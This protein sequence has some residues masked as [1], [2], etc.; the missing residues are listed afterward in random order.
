MTPPK[1]D[2]YGPERTSREREAGEAEVGQLWPTVEAERTLPVAA[3]M[4]TTPV[5]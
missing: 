4:T 2:V 5:H 1:P 3:S